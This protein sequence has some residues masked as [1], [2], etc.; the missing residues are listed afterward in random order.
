MSLAKYSL[1]EL[2]QRVDNR[3]LPLIHLVDMR[4]ENDKRNNLSILSQPLVEALRQRVQNR[5][6][7]IL[8]LNR[9]GFNTTMLCPD[10]GHVETCKDCSIALTFHRRMVLRCH[11]CGFRKPAP[12]SVTNVALSTS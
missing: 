6:Q 9:R 7:S 10:C 3:E 1:S 11:L 12:E 2:T 4:R 5:E 8:F